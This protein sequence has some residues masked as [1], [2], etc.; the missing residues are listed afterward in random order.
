MLNRGAAAADRSRV[1]ER[2]ELVLQVIQH[3]AVI[4]QAANDAGVDRETLER[5]R[6][7]FIA[8]GS[9]HLEQQMAAEN[10]PPRRRLGEILIDSGVIADEQLREA[11]DLQKQ[12]GGLLGE[13]LVD[14]GHA[15]PAQVF[16]A[17]GDQRRIAEAAW[18]ELAG[19]LGPHDLF[20][21]RSHARREKCSLIDAALSEG[22]TTPSELLRRALEVAAK[23]A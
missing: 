13:I 17:L 2:A 21:V 12:S 22:S 7:E 20:R 23:Q 4:A 6:D 8:A 3:P 16:E 10:Q 15:S 1:I 11:L 9:D 5:W 19:D 18:L 14:I